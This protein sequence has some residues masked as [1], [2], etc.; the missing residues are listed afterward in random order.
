MY[1]LFAPKEHDYAVSSLLDDLPPLIREKVVKD[2]KI[3]EALLQ[4]TSKKPKLDR[5]KISSFSTTLETI[6]RGIEP[7]ID[8]P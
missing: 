5:I 3:T 8:G 1:P 4:N 2:L 6:T 7:F